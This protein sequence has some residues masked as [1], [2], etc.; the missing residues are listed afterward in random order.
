[1]LDK[2][3]LELF[4]DKKIQLVNDE[5]FVIT[6]KI[7]GIYDNSIAFFTDGKTIYIGFDRI[8]EVRP[9]GGNSY[10]R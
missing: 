5:H 3:I 9:L 8:L 10:D 4:F 6:G 1:M 7:T 2:S